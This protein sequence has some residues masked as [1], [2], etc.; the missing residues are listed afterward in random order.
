MRK[1]NEEL[2]K[3]SVYTAAEGKNGR[4]R[5][6]ER[7]G[8]MGRAEALMVCASTSVSGHFICCV[9]LFLFFGRYVCLQYPDYIYLSKRR[10]LDCK[11]GHT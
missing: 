11:K 7:T 6:R 1:K 4:E 9:F 10:Y 2:T 8:V 5:G 3:G